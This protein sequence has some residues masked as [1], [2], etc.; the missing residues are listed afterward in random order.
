[1]S[2]NTEPQIRL[3]SP[4]FA[5]DIKRNPI[6]LISPGLSTCPLI[7]DTMLIQSWSLDTTLNTSQL[8]KFSYSLSQHR[9]WSLSRSILFHF[10]S[11]YKNMYPLQLSILLTSILFNSIS[12]A[13]IYII[14]EFVCWNGPEAWNLLK[15]VKEELQQGPSKTKTIFTKIISAPRSEVH[16][17]FN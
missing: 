2:N 12:H 6:D 7:I 14:L 4:Y 1:M 16:Y 17:I 10:M 11:T 5:S 15:I 8:T 3:V 13:E 9:S